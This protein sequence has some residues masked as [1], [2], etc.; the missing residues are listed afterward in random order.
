MI[1]LKTK[2]G[3]KLRILITDTYEINTED[4][5][6][7]FSSDKKL[8]DF[9]NYSNKSKYYNDS[10]TIVIGKMNHY[11]SGVTI[12]KFVGLK[13]KMFSLFVDN[14]SEHKKA[15]GMNRNVVEKITHNEYKDALLNNKC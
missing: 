11:T 2:Y 12:E 1:T 5:Y 6:E 3:N 15:K 14:N 8:F 7:D 4:V 9:S 13:P 10:N